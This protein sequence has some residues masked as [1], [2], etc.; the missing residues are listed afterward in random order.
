MTSPAGVA[1]RSDAL[2][3]ALI[4]ALLVLRVGAIFT[5]G[6]DSDEPQNLHVVYRWAKGDLPYLDQFDNHTPLLHALFLPFAALVGENVHVVALARLALVPLSFGVVGL[7]Y[8][9]CRRLFDR[10]TALWSVAITL[11]LADWSLKSIEFRPDILW[12]FLWF[13]ALWVL[14]PRQGAA[15]PGRFFGAGIL[16]GAAAATSVKTVF[17]LPALALSWAGAWLLSPRFRAWFP[18]GV[19]L[20]AAL[21]GAAGFV[22]VPGLVAGFF[23]AH[24]ALDDMV[25]CVYAINRDPFFTAR[26]WL[27]LAGLP[28]AAAVAFRLVRS[29]PAGAPYRGAVF[30]A[31]AAYAL[32]IVAFGPPESLAKQTF[33]PAY[34]ILIAAA[35][36]LILSL[37]RWRPWQ[38]AT[39]GG[40]VCAGL[41]IAMIW[42]SPPWRDAMAAHREGLRAILTHTAPGDFVM[43]MKGETIFRQRPVYLAYVGNTRRAM[44]EGRLAAPDPQKLLETRTAYA[45]DRTAGFPDAMQDFL[46]ETYVRTDA[47]LRVAGRWLKPSWENGRWVAQI[48]T[49][50]PGSY[51]LL[52][53]GRVAGEPFLDETKPSTLVF[54]DRRARCLFWKAA[55]ESGLRPLPR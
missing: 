54:P 42:G 31:A 28:L 48:G 22:I 51:V 40:G 23:A 30:L 1:P 11:A 38:V 2:A 29:D 15:G 52:E 55:W 14:T 8:A 36:H 27:F 43:D 45:I 47:G 18:V 35:C 17:L 19:I 49:V 50:I 25:F 44:A 4:V 33:L 41:A 16:L 20:R 46:K 24:G 37:R 32:A 39:M 9:L 7:L 26:S 53:E 12:V 5:H 21:A 34:P 6:V 3:L 13:A 10:S